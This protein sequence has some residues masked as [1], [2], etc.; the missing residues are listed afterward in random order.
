MG[1]AFTGELLA[2]G[3]QLSAVGFQLSAFGFRLSASGY[4][5]LRGGAVGIGIGIGWPP[6]RHFDQSGEISRQNGADG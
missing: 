2:L 3:F 1:Q 4:R 6:H 5:L